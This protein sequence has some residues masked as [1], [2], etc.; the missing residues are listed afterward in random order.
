[1]ALAA[2]AGR[3]PVPTVVASELPAG[4]RLSDA[5]ERAAY[6]VVAEALVNVAKHASARRCEI[7]CRLDGGRLV[8][9]VQDDGNGG[10]MVVPGG[11]LA[12]LAGRMEA[13]DGTLLVTSPD[14]GPTVVRAEIGL[15][16]AAQSPQGSGWV[17]PAQDPR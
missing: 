10:A 12:G 6:F 1:P 17:L 14:G 3:S 5:I 15:P 11:G 2:L 4:L 13:L 9:E 16:A 7:R 8:I